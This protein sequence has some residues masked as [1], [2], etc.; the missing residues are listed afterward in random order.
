MERTR[1]EQGAVIFFAAWAMWILLAWPFAGGG[2][3]F[4]SLVVGALV[5]LIPAFWFAE[6]TTPSGAGLPLPRR[7]FW[8]LCY[9][10]LFVVYC[11]Q[12]NLDVVY[13]VLHPEMPIRPGIVRIRTTLK[14]AVGRTTLANCITLTPGTLVV[15]ITDEGDLYIHWI[16]VRSQDPAEAARLIAGR[17]ERILARICP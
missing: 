8:A 5:A 12:A 10:A 6:R 9:A 4:S 14:S 3:M 16:W 1:A 11:V 17:F 2:L 7:A 15:D 13:R